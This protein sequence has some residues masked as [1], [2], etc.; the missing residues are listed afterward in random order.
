MS[1]DEQKLLHKICHT[2]SPGVL[3][4]KVFFQNDELCGDSIN[5]FFEINQVQNQVMAV[6]SIIIAGQKR[7]VNK[8]M[9]YKTQWIQKYYTDPMRRLTSKL[10]T[11]ARPAPTP[12][13]IPHTPYTISTPSSGHAPNTRVKYGTSKK[14]Y[15]ACA[16]CTIFIIVIIII[17]AVASAVSS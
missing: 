9:T 3:Q 10:K 7:Q 12:Q 4:N 2:F 16:V 15:I 14:K 13:P 1:A 11:P 5:E 8:I 17:S 6:E